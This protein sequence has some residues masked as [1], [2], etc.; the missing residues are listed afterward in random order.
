MET[1]PKLPLVQQF[2]RTT[3]QHK[4]V[5]VDFFCD[6]AIISQGGTPSVVFGPGNIAQAHTADEWISINSL[7]SA[8]RILEKF[9]RSLP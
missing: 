3:G 9:L 6:A 5:G 4:A 8:T 2:M 7:E 1:S